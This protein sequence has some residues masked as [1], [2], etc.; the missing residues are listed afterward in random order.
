MFNKNS[1]Q[2]VCKSKKSLEMHI[3][4]THK[5]FLGEV[6]LQAQQPHKSCYFLCFK[7]LL[8][9]ISICC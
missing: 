6:D 3:C 7:I 2:C 4:I 8:Q 1:H 9:Q 5:K